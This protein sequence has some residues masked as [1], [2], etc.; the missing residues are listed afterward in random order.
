MWRK[1]SNQT[2][3]NK[4]SIHNEYINLVFKSSVLAPN[5]I[6]VNYLQFAL[7]RKKKFIDNFQ[8]NPYQDNSAVPLWPDCVLWKS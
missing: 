7:Y 5:H 4:Q 2:K 6:T 1:E 3:Q 8:I